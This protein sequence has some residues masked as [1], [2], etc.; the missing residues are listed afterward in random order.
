MENKIILKKNILIIGDKGYIGTTLTNYLLKKLKNKINITGLDHNLFFLN[1]YSKKKLKI[2]NINQDC[3]KVILKDIG[4][5]PDVIIF[6]AAVSNDP[7]GNE[8][9]KATKEINFLSCIRLAQQA[10][11]LGV[12]KFIFASSCSMYGSSGNSLRKEND[13]LSPITDYAKSKVNAEKR[14]EKISSKYFNIISLR[15]ATA[16]GLSENLRLD[17]VFND[18]IANAVLEKKII[19]LSSGISW[20]PLIHVNDIS[21]AIFWSILFDTKKNFL[22]LNV[23]SD[24]WNFRIIDLAKKISKLIPG[25]KVLIENSSNHDK[26]SYRVNFNLFKK[27]AP[28][29]QPSMNFKKA[30]NEMIYFLKK[31]KKNLKNF[32]TSP[33]WSRLACLKYLINKKYINK[34]LYKIT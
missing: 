31:E 28:K 33:K 26:R 30:V 11:K 10:K 29:H 3:R 8:F 5:I 22:A 9:K 6:L 1:K 27:L 23:G 17:L 20:R 21:K 4:Q 32:R 14:L 12:K 13:K 15:F 24:K 18:F 25:S 2:R 19:L 34:K 7:M 16:A